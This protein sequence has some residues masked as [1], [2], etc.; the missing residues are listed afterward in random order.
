MKMIREYIKKL[1]REEIVPE[2]EITE[3]R[4]LSNNVLSVY[5][6]LFDT[7]NLADKKYANSFLEIENNTWF[8]VSRIEYSE[9]FHA[10][11]FRL[12]FAF[13][14]KKD[15]S[16]FA[17]E[18]LNF[19]PVYHAEIKIT[20]GRYQPT[21]IEVILD[22]SLKEH[23]LEYIKNNPMFKQIIIHEIQHLNT[24]YVHLKNMWKKRKS[25]FG[26]EFIQK[27]LST[28]FLNPDATQEFRISHLMYYM[29]KDELNSVIAQIASSGQKQDN[30][31]YQLFSHYKN[32]TF[33]QF[34]QELNEYNPKL[35][36]DKKLYLKV[37]DRI[38]YFF[39]KA[40]KTF[41]GYSP[42]EAS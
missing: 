30:E 34:V 37:L 32:L 20:S 38:K 28:Q 6:Q 18:F 9:E 17:V 10:V 33:E 31:I 5:E 7:K 14:N 26:P 39:R 12:R 29:S 15:K 42:N 11:E 23:G 3:E 41:V 8:T 4:G 13:I 1:L 22:D 40:D 19:F 24:N 21:Y 2:Q 16:S 35:K 36:V 25:N 27:R